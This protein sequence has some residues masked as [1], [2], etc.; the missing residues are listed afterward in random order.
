M[1]KPL[2]LKAKPKVKAKKPKMKK[3]PRP[4]NHKGGAPKGNEFWRIA[5]SHGPDKKYTPAELLAKAQE[6]FDWIGENPITRDLG[7]GKKQKLIRPFTNEGFCLFAGID[8]Q[9]FENYSQGIGYQ[10]YFD[11]CAHIRSHI[12]NN[13]L[14]GASIGIFNAAIIARD[15][16][17]V[18]RQERDIGNKAGEPFKTATVTAEITGDMDEKTASQIYRTLLNPPKQES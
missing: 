10:D 13:K 16:G 14:E 6:Y 3:G 5:M 8:R 18:D 15:L 1:A 12:R 7:G 17:L 2:I 9:T 4:G 11:I